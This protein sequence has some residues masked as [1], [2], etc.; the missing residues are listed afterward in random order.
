VK[1]L[2]IKTCYLQNIQSKRFMAYVC[3]RLTV[4][5]LSDKNNQAYFENDIYI[6]ILCLVQTDITIKMKFH[7]VEKLKNILSDYF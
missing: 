2:A 5:L 6:Y 1:Q 7:H 3:L 4:M